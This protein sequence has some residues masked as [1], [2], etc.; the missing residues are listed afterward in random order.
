MSPLSDKPLQI[1]R[2]LSI[3]RRETG[4]DFD[5]AALLQTVGALSEALSVALLVPVLHLMGPTRRGIEMDIGGYEITLSLPVLL[6]AFVVLIIARALAL[7]RKEVFNARV[8]FGFSEAM[9]GRLFAAL[10]KTRWSIVSSWRTADMTHVVTGNSDRLL[11]AISLLLSFVQS[12]T[13]AVILTLLSLFLSWQMTLVALGGGAILLLVTFPMRRRTLEQ[14]RKLSAALRDKYRITDEFLNGLRT[15]KAFGLEAQHVGA[16]RVVLDNI[17]QGNLQFAAARAAATTIYQVVTAV[18]LAGF[19]YFALSVF[20]LGLPQTLAL[21]LL[22]MRLAPRMIAL[23]TTWQ[24]LLVQIGGVET[25]LS[26]LEAAEKGAEARLAPTDIPR[27][28]QALVIR[29]ATYTYG[30]AEKAALEAVSVTIPAG[31]ITALV[32]PTGCGKSTLVDMMLGLIQPDQGEVLIDG[33]ELSAERLRGWQTRIGYVPQETF[34]FNA[35]IAENLRL[36]RPEAK[37]ADLWEVLQLADAMNF[38]RTLAGQLDHQVGDRGGSLSGGERQRLAIARALLRKPDLLIL[39]E[40]TSA[41]DALS[42][43]RIAEALRELCGQMTTIAVA[44]RASMVAFADN[45]ILLEAG[46]VVA[47]GPLASMIEASAGSFVREMIDAD[48]KAAYTAS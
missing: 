43:R 29:D 32:G 16:M 46:K 37:D 26:M 36:A 8:T 28:R 24:E 4:R 3:V 18:A 10:A 17:K 38:V 25:V 45:V 41:L 2:L 11:Q 9:T 47:S 19:V 23:H 22:Y 48:S 20:D 1:A 34:L 44:H 7:Q 33:D 27:L 21:L 13:M 40:A 14:G 42:Q 35:S 15:A 6:A 31:K 30:G 39:D 5:K 12:I